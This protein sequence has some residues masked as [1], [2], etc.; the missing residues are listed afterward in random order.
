VRCGVVL[1]N[2]SDTASKIVAAK[3][4]RQR[5]THIEAGRYPAARDAIPVLN[6][7]SA[8]TV[9]PIKG[10]KSRTYQCELA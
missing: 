9:A 4:C 3:A 7:R 6:D 10:S 8:F 2:Q 5:E 1:Q